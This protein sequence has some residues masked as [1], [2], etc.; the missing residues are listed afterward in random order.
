MG[1]WTGIRL[2]NLELKASLRSLEKY[3]GE[4]SLALH[5]LI[6]HC[7]VR[8][9]GSGHYENRGGPEK[10]RIV[11]AGDV[12]LYHGGGSNRWFSLIPDL[13]AST[14]VVFRRMDGFYSAATEAKAS[15]KVPLPFVTVGAWVA[16]QLKHTTQ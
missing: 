11:V 13:D 12:S 9:S 6:P 7:T 8:I 1:E 15:W 14:Q 4:L 5:Q 16:V 3:G 10:D 2:S